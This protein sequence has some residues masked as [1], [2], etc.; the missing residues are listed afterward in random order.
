MPRQRD[1]TTAMCNE[2][3]QLLKELLTRGARDCALPRV[4]RELGLPIRN[5]GIN[6]G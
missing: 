4:E 3:W 5:Q 6:D 2:V 1:T